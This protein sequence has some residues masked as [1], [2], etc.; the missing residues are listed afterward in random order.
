MLIVTP[1]TIV[2]KSKDLEFEVIDNSSGLPENE[3]RRIHKD[4]EGLMWFASYN[5]LLRYDGYEFKVFKNTKD[6]PSLLHSNFITELSDDESRI[7]IGT[8]NGLNYLDKNTGRI[9]PSRHK[10]PDKLHIYGILPSEYLEKHART[11]GE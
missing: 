4:K 1:A 5:G 7:W 11:K 9:F 2:G 8:D 10:H 3:I 6:H